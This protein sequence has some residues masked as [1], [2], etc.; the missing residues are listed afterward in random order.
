V[1]LIDGDNDPHLPP[2]FT[3]TDTTLVRVFLR[4]G[5]LPP[6]SLERKLTGLPHFVSVSSPKGGAN[7]ADFVM[8]LHVGILHATLPMHIPFMIVTADKSLSVAVQ[9]LQ[10]VGRQATLW[11]SHPENRGAARKRAEP[12]SAPA[13]AQPSAGGRGRSRGRGRGR[14]RAA[15]RRQPAASSSAAPATT[16]AAPKAAVDVSA[17]GGRSLAEIAAAYA[18]RLARIK[19][20]PSRLKTLLN[21]ITNRAGAAGYSAELILDELKARHGV[22]VDESG[23]VRFTPPNPAP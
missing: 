23:K 9:E 22:V 4:T 17:P 3:I 21:D 2:E 18:A 6:R 5:A 1:L 19:D 12:A 15:G 11:T 8:S 20:P 16:A 14:G 7:A 13:S 10:R